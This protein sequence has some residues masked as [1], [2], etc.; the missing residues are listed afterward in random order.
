MIQVNLTAPFQLSKNFAKH[1]LS[2]KKHGRIINIG[3]LLSFQGLHKSIELI[4]GGKNVPA[5]SSS[6]GGIRQ[7]T[8]ALSNAWSRHGILVNAIAPGY[9]E[10]DMTT[11]LVADKARYKEI[12]DRTPVGRWGKPEELVGP[13][14]FLASQASSFVTGEMLVVDGGWMGW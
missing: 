7:L 14:V 5:Y 3:S 13:A 1:L 4:L 9:I 10:T 11:A 6:K 8:Q 12:T 2:Q